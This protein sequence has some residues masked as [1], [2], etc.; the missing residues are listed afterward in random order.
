MKL[1][2]GV[3]A[4]VP[5]RNGMWSNL[6]FT[7]KYV[8]QGS[9]TLASQKIPYSKINSIE[10]RS[11]SCTL[12]KHSND[13]LYA[14]MIRAIELLFLSFPLTEKVRC[15]YIKKSELSWLHFTD[16]MIDQFY[17]YSLFHTTA[18]VSFI[19]L[20]MNEQE[21]WYSWKFS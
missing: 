17:T 3:K 4:S 2:H 21:I 13:Q 14:Q 11:I 5:G 16:A 1:Y 10:D 19:N 18:W 8:E 12:L 7:S 15:N 9:Q 6:R 20:Y